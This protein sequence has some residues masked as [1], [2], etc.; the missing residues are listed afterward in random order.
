MDQKTKAIDYHNSIYFTNSMQIASLINYR[1]DSGY[2]TNTVQ[3]TAITSI[4]RFLNNKL[5][6]G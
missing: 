4:C 1:Y 5:E 6:L 3:P 2:H